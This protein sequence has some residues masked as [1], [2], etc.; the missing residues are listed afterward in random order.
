MRKILCA[1]VL[2]AFATPLL[3]SDPFVGTWTLNPEKTKYT[4]GAPPKNVT[5]VIEEQGNNLQITA[6]GK[7]DDGKPIAVKY[8][9]PLKGGMGS[10]Q[11]GDFDS[12]NSKRVSA[13]VR[14]NSYMKG[15]KEIRT[16]HAVVS[17]D[18]K[19]ISNTVKGTGADG[20]PVAGVDVFDKQ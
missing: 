8:T 14:N 2:M 1:L 5:L 10:V 20:K 9:V 15:G 6:T 4:A 19:T 3:A 17:E 13:N 7:S 12:V 18:G 16:R 11:E